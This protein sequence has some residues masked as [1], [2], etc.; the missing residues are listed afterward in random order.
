MSNV[1]KLNHAEEFYIENISSET[2]NKFVEPEQTK[3][4]TKHDLT[5]LKKMMNI[6]VDLFDSDPEYL[7]YVFKDMYI[8]FKKKEK[9][10]NLINRRNSSKYWRAINLYF[11]LKDQKKVS[12]TKALNYA[13]KDLNKNGVDNKHLYSIIQAFESFK[14]IRI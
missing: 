11:Y 14:K 10:D 13:K 6:L 8:Q 5:S 2:Y 1:I 12:H 4:N 7:A 9:V 3:I